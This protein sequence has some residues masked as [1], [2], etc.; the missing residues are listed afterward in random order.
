M[1]AKKKKLDVITAEELGISITSGV[2]TLSIREPVKRVGGSKVP[3]VDAL[4]EKMKAF[5]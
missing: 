5:I 4:L 2:E 1:K 3:D